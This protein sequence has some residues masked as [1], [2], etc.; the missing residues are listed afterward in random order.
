MQEFARSAFQH[1]HAQNGDNQSDDKG[2]VDTRLVEQPCGKR[3]E[4]RRHIGEKRRIGDRS[5][6][7]R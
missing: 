5:I 4:N 7:Q 6:M 3:D 1:D 2:R